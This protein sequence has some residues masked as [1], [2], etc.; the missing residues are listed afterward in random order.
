MELIIKKE[1]TVSY[2]YLFYIYSYIYHFNNEQIGQCENILDS[3][4][5]ILV[6]KK[7]CENDNLLWEIYDLLTFFSKIPKF[8]RKFYDKYEYIFIKRDFYEKDLITTEKLK[9]IHN[10][11]IN[12][13]NEGIKLFL[14]KDNGTILNLILFSLKLLTNMF[15]N[16]DIINKD[17][18]IKM[19]YESISILLLITTYQDLTQSLLENKKCITLIIDT[20]SSIISYDFNIN[21]PLLNEICTNIYQIVCNII[22]WQHKI[23]LSHFKYNNIHLKIKNKFD[24]YLRTNYINE[25]QFIWLMDIIGYIFENEKNNCFEK[26][27][28]KS[29]LDNN[30]FY[31]VITNIL[32]KFYNNNIHNKIM[33]FLIIYYPNN[34]NNNF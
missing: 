21:N 25:I 19:F 2:I 17:K 4:L 8:T 34:N 3:L 1:T 5:S 6:T 14:Q 20:F 23:F 24:F 15:S 26:E 13:N 11:F 16:N 7:N 12:S 30:N 32:V 22:R 33:G 18:K 29:D 10:I 28:I 27:K 9:I 31:D